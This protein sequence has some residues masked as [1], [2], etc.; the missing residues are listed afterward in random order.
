MKF[1]FHA[2][3]CLLLVTTIVP[4]VAGTE[5]PAEL[6]SRGPLQVGEEVSYRFE[7]THPYGAPERA[8]A[9]VRG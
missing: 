7:T 3:F 9:A 8:D 6:I 1:R 4:V 5:E 2:V